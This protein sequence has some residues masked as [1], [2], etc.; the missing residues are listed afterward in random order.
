M[1]TPKDFQLQCPIP[2]NDYPRITMAHGGGGKISHQLISDMFQ[3]LF[4]NEFLNAEHDGV[5]LPTDG[6]KIAFATD[7]HV[8]QPLFFPGG[9]IGSLAVYG[10]VNDLAMCGAR[11]MY[12]SLSFIIEEGLPTETLWRIVQSIKAASEQAGVKIVTGDTKV[13]N[14]AKGDELFINTSGV[15]IVEHDLKIQPSS[16]QDGDVIILNGDVGRHGI[17]IMAHR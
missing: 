6:K 15:G 11:P 16:I 2:L 12:L 1:E 13:I 8:I 14:R 3:P 10:T 9:D 7:S 5:V 4:E 17:A